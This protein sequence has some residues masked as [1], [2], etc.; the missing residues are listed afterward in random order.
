MLL[1]FFGNETALTSRFILCFPYCYCTSK[2]SII[3][4]TNTCGS[5]EPGLLR[6][7]QIAL[8]GPNDHPPTGKI[9]KETLRRRNLRNMKKQYGI[10]DVSFLQFGLI[11]YHL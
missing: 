4:G 8:L 6:N 7:D 3:V 11:F 1:E 5:C 2:F 10:F 9:S